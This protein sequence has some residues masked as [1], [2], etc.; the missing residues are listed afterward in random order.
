M[1]L[2]DSQVISRSSLMRSW[3]K[4]QG[5]DGWLEVGLEEE[6]SDEVVLGPVEL[7]STAPGIWCRTGL[8]SPRIR[9][10][11]SSREDKGS[12]GPLPVFFT[13]RIAAFSLMLR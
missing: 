5:V 2:V 13:L 4:V 1:A 10:V 11:I 8:V 3:A 9:W 7:M 12:Q 6:G